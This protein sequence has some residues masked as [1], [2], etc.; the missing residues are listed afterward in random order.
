MRLW[1][2]GALMLSGCSTFDPYSRDQLGFWSQCI[3]ADAWGLSGVTQF[4]PWNVGAITWKRNVAC[5]ESIRM[6]EWG[7]YRPTGTAR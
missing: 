3:E 4:G 5:D 7:I 1:I 2:I 6:R